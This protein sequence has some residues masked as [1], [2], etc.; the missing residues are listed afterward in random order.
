MRPRLRVKCNIIKV[1]TAKHQV[2]KLMIVTKENSIAGRYNIYV[3]VVLDE[4]QTR[5]HNIGREPK[6]TPWSSTN[7][8]ASPF[9][10]SSP[11]L[12][13]QAIVGY[14]LS[15]DLQQHLE[16]CPKRA[17]KSQKDRLGRVLN[18]NSRPLMPVCQS[19]ILSPPLRGMRNAHCKKTNIP[20]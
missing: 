14:A 4:I 1:C 3:P 15:P 12:L 19:N 17:F 7:G 5:I 11:S 6:V 2:R 20:P 10:S 8:Q 9:L 13:L 16:K 18:A